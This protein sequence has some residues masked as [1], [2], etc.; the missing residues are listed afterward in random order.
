MAYDKSKISLWDQIIE[1]G[2]KEFIYVT[3]DT[4]AQVQAAGYVSNATDLRLLPGDLVHVFSATAFST[5]GLSL[6]AEVFPAPTVGVSNYFTTTPSYRLFQVSTVAAGTTAAPGAGTL[7]PAMVIPSDLT[8]LPRN[9]IDCGDFTTNPWQIGTSFN[10]NGPSPS[11]TADRWNAN[12]GTSLVWT[13]G[14]VADTTVQGFSAAYQWGRSVGDT[15]TVGLSLGQVVETLDAIRCQGQPIVL[16]FWNLA[17]AQFA[18]GA[19]GS[20]FTASII[21][22]TGVDEVSGKMFSGSWSGCTTV[23]TQTITPGTTWSRIGPIGGVVPTNATQLGVAFSYV[24]TTA[25]TS[26]GLTAGLHESLRFG[27][28]QLEV[29]GMTPFEHTDVA[30]VINIATRYLQVINEPTVGMAIGPAAFSASSIAQVHIPLPSPMRKAPT[31]TFTPGGFAI[32]DSALGA[33]LISAGGLQVGSQN[34][35]TMLVTA[36]ATLTAGLVSFMQG[37]STNSGIIILNADY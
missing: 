19:S 1:G 14:R 21:A 33:H 24:A 22:G 15:H 20:I 3:T 11:L 7:V 6:G 31:L 27:G 13:A 8:A 29:G 23:A 4:L 9:L 26:P 28:I 36:A 37:R 30:E 12:S 10:G 25:A 2:I 16:S 35:V 34:A 18:A 17:D 5:T 32:T